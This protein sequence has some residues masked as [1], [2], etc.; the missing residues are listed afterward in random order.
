MHFTLQFFTF[1]ELKRE[2]KNVQLV[3]GGERGNWIP[4]TFFLQFQEVSKVFQTIRAFEEQERVRRSS[5]MKSPRHPR[6]N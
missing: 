6:G 3:C 5:V 4:A 1:L 2:A